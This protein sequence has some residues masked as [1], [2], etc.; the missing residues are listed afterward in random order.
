MPRD[1][2]EQVPRMRERGSVEDQPSFGTVAAAPVGAGG[3]GWAQART[4]QLLPDNAEPWRRVKDEGRAEHTDHLL[5]RQSGRHLP[6]VR[7][8]AN[9]AGQTDAERQTHPME[10]TAVRRY[11][12]AS[13]GGAAALGLRI[14]GD[15]GCPPHRD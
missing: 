7:K 6:M 12:A 3:Q 13:R 9:M 14:E 2:M 8:P 15:R 11:P 1:A 10:Q 4:S 5:R